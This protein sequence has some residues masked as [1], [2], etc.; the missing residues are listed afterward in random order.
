MRSVLGRVRVAVLMGVIMSVLVRPLVSV[1][2][3]LM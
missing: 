2:L 1:R 3:V